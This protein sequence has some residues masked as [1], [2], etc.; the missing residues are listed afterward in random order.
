MG[1]KFY[2]SKKPALAETGSEL[3]QK[4]LN[5]NKKE[6]KIIG[7]LS[8]ISLVGGVSLYLLHKQRKKNQTAM[9]NQIIKR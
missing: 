6:Q 5:L 3:G 2:I 1:I 4:V 8:G 7:W 9:I